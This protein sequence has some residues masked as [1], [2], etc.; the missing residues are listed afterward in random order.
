MA[1][2]AILWNAVTLAIF[3]RSGNVDVRIA[4]LIKKDVGIAR[5]IEKKLI[6]RDGIP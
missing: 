2:L 3:K 1:L 4:R 6:L 5:L